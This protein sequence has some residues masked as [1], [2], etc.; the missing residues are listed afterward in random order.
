MEQFVGEDVGEHG[1]EHKPVVYEKQPHLGVAVLQVAQRSMCCYSNG[2]L[3]GPICPVC[4]LM[5][6]ERGWKAGFDVL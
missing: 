6:V 5:R 4:K 2:I 3:S 1:V